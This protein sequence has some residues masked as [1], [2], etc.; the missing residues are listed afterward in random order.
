MAR[1]RSEDYENIQASI[2]ENTAALFASR[3]YAATSIGDIATACSCSKSR[4]YHYFDSKDKI[5][6]EMLTG[7]IDMLI[8]DSEEVLKDLNDPLERF[9]ALIRYFMSV[10]AVSK[11][12]HIVLLTCLEFLPE[13][14]HKDVEAKERRLVGLVQEILE[15]LRPDIASDKTLMHVDT[16]LFFGMINWTYTWFSAKGP[17]SP[18]E[19]ADRCVE[20]F[21][22]GFRQI[23]GR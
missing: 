10:Y 11:E 1:T 20:L 18:E 2:L 6:A 9:R 4:L 16:M 8:E 14:V 23:S 15:Q 3:G 5:L 7:H 21:L 12:K 13:G 19:L 22:N 17:I